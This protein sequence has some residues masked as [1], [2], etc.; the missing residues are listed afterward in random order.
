MSTL[1]VLQV[2]PE[3]SLAFPVPATGMNH[4]DNLDHS[5]GFADGT[6]L[7]QMLFAFYVLLCLLVI[8]NTNT[9]TL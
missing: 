9:K 7:V 4:L 8:V 1:Q 2:V 3:L 6:F 5:K